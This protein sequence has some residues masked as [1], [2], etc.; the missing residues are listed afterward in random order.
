MN[1]SLSTILFLLIA[2]VA[3]AQLYV[4][5]NA[6]L[7]VSEGAELQVGGNLEND[8]AI[9]NLGTISLYR[10]WLI[11]N[12]FNGQEGELQF[13]GS[14]D[15]RIHS[16]D[17]VLGGLTLNTL[18]SV[19][20]PG[21]EYLVSDKIDFQYGT[22]Q[23]GAGTRFILG[24]DI[25]VLG[26]SSAS[27]FDGPLIASG[28]G[29]KIFPVG[30]DGAY[31]PLTLLDVFGNN[32]EIQ[33]SYN[34]NNP[35]VPEVTGD[36]LL[37]VSSLGY[38]ELE[39]INGTSDETAIQLEFEQEDI[40]D[41]IISNNIRYR[42]RSPTIAF[43]RDLSDKW[44]SLGV[45]E[46]TDSDSL[47][48]GKITAEFPFTPQLN[49]KQYFAIGLAPTVPPKGLLYVPEVF[50]PNASDP[51]NKF[52]KIFGEKITNE[53]FNFRIYNRLGV[54]V[55]STNS[56]IEAN[57]NGWDGTNPSG[58]EEATGV[59]Y[60]SLQLTFEDGRTV[61]DGGSFYLIR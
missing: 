37:G 38:W 5:A 51:D 54:I 10:N 53:E 7:H 15:Q 28:S 29:I 25:T 9:Q 4:G 26:G 27:Y 24:E 34:R 36:T 60:Y 22:V 19:T 41:A 20:F 57:E 30:A 17:L 44:R 46:I 13:K 3:N 12:N 6:L 18:G 49:R 59:Y 1:K 2:F 58:A 52:F 50:S 16:T 11:N 42:F 35:I 56:F 40:S 21:G 33:V 43:T 55:Y 8:G 45:S 31:G 61:N 47:T 14:G 32:A 39:L 48:Y 23:I